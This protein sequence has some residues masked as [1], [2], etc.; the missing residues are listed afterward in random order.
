MY[1][2]IF[3][4][5]LPCIVSNITVPLLGMVDTAIVGHLGAP[6]YLGAIAVGG[7]I[8][9]LIYWI[10][11]FLRMGTGGLTAQ[12]FGRRDEAESLRTL[13]RSLGVAAV[14]S[15]VLIAVQGL[16]LVGVFAFV[17]ATPEVARLASV[18]FRILIWGAPAVLGL[19][20][21]TGWFIGMQNARFPMYVAIVQNVVNIAVSLLL[22]IVLGM[23]V[24]GVAVGTLVAQY[25]GLLTAVGLWWRHYRGLAARSAFGCGLWQRAALL[26]FFGVNRDIFLR[27]L[28]LVGVTTYFTAA[29]TA[30]GELVLAANTLLMQFFVIF[31]YFMDGFAYA[32]EALGGRFA[33]ARAVDDFRR[34]LSRLFGVGGAVA[35]LFL[36][37][38]VGGGRSFLSMFTD[39]ARVIA[40]AGDYLPL[41]CLVPVLGVAAF[42]FDG[43]YIGV[44]A[45]REMLLTMLAATAVFFLVCL[46][47]PA[48]NHFLW[49]A[50]LAYLA[51]RGLLQAL[52]C[53]HVM[54]RTFSLADRNKRNVP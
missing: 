32:G 26:R 35:L 23:K 21:F 20:G 31:S 8:F 14:V 4:I 37:A 52:F 17:D 6:A 1:R 10:F 28:C 50:F 46:L 7:M 3:R 33:G 47:A 34:L 44:T 43:L 36:V 29:G 22:V 5:A 16:L 40:V 27:T 2:S 19:Y 15:V 30:Q 24:E 13:F 11:G 9:N 48:D 39:D 54:R 42:L 51:L 45:T 53:R 49:T 41:V 38:Y 12:A 18:Y 25:A